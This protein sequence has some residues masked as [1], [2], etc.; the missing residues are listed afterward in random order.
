MSQKVSYNFYMVISDDV[1]I[2]KKV[3]FLSFFIFY[4]DY[5]VP[6]MSKMFEN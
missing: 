4:E 6:Y 3:I 2:L 5:I 1:I